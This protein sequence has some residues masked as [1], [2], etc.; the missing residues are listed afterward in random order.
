M[1]QLQLVS[2]SLSCPLAFLILSF[3]F[4]EFSFCG[5]PGWQNSLFGWFSLLSTITRSGRLVEIRWCGCI[6]KSQ[7]GL[8]ILISWTVSGLCI[9]HSIEW[10]NFNFLHN[11]QWITLPT[12]LCLILYSFCASL[13]HLL[14][15]INDN[16]NDNYYYLLLVSFSHQF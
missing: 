10:S 13:L 14:I 6:S 16:D 9:C 8:C 11:S 4:I 5:P 7:R 15:V 2:L 12:Q 1:H 3:R